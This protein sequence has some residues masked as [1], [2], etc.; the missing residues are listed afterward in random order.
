MM[1]LRFG[2]ERQQ[3][4][5]DARGGQEIVELRRPGEA[6]HAGH[7]PGRA[8]PAQRPETR[9]A[10]RPAPPARPARPGPSR[11]PGS[12]CARAACG[13]DQLALLASRPRRRRV[14]GNAGSAAWQTNSAIC[15]AMPPSSMRTTQ[16]LAAASFSL[17]SASTPAPMLKMPLSRG[18]SSRN[19]CGGAHTTAWSACGAPGR[20]S[21]TVGIAAAPRAALPATGAGFGVGAA[22]VKFA[23][24]IDFESASPTSAVP[25]P[26]PPG[27]PART[28]ARPPCRRP[29][30]RSCAPS[31]SPPSP[32]APGPCVTLSPA[33]TANDITLPGIGAVRRPASACASP[34]WA[35][36]SI[37]RICVAPRALNTWSVSPSA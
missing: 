15:T 16:R 26:R 13:N 2:R 35:S 17:S 3:A 36:R 12:R 28:A 22:E 5:Q 27:R 33:L 8:A 7:V 32:P 9:T 21:S 6:A 29:A 24:G 34:A 18:C 11:R 23:W 31:S 37:A 30:P 10:P 14:R 4:D 1:P 20:H 25:P 19:C